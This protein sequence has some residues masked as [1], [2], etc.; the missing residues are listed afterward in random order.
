MWVALR[1]LGVRDQLVEIIQSFHQNMK[2]QT[3]PGDT[4][5]EEID[6]DNGV[7]QGCCMAPALFNLYLCEFVE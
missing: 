5:L 2:A 6:V 7:R 3:H 1:K 4:L